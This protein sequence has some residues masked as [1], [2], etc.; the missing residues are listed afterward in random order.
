ML[1]SLLRGGSQTPILGSD[2]VILQIAGCRLGHIGCST[3]HSDCQTKLSFNKVTLFN[4]TLCK[5]AK[6]I[7]LLHPQVLKV[8][9]VQNDCKVFFVAIVERGIFLQSLS[10]ADF[11]LKEI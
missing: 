6:H 11:H 10:S 9:E 4:C 8:K 2:W 3:L 5:Q 1:S 7:S